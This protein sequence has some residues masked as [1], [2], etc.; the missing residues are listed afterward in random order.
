MTL[1]GGEMRVGP[2]QVLVD[3]YDAST[4]TVY[5]FHGCLWHGCVKC[6]KNN[7]HSYTTVHPDCTLYEVHEHT[8]EKIKTLKDHGHRVIEKWECEWDQ[9]VKTDQALKHFLAVDHKNVDPL[10]PRDAFFGGRTNAIKLH[11]RVT[12]PEKIKYM[13]V[14]SLYPWVNK[15][16]EYHVGHPDI[17]VNPTDQDIHHYFGMALVDVLPPL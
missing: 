1:N 13:D 11:H 10:Q 3:G 6:F 2:Q 4:N 12:G 15:T 16:G 14:T 7:R 5:E 17:I 9:D 8:K